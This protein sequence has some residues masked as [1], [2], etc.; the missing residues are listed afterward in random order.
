MKDDILNYLGKSESDILA[1]YRVKREDNRK[2]NIVYSEDI[3]L[4]VIYSKD[5]ILFNDMVVETEYTNNTLTVYKY[6]ADKINNKFN[7]ISA[8]KFYIWKNADTN[9]IVGFINKEDVDKKE[10]Y[11]EKPIIMEDGQYDFK[12]EY[13]KFENKLKKMLGE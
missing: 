7:N 13:S 3:S 4:K 10:L 5:M 11:L 6:V 12:I 2:P 1:Y 9:K 8:E